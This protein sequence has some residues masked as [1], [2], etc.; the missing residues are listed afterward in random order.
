MTFCFYDIDWFNDKVSILIDF[1]TLQYSMSSDSEITCYDDDLYDDFFK[2]FEIFLGCYDVLDND[3]YSMNLTSNYI[4]VIENENIDYPECIDVDETSMKS[5]YFNYIWNYRNEFVYISIKNIPH[6]HL[7]LFTDICYRI[8]G[9]LFED[10][11]INFYKQGAL[12]NYMNYW[13]HLINVTN[14]KTIDDFLY[15]R[16]VIQDLEDNDVGYNKSEHQL[17]TNNDIVFCDNI[18]SI[19]NTTNTTFF[20]LRLLQSPDRV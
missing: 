1:E 11:V 5:K 6:E 8:I 7:S 2:K 17:L 10:E 13:L 20:N 15:M 3:I 18:N 9:E 16:L 4:D 14:S 12:L 19:P